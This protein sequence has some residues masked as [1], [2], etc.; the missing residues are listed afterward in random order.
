MTMC[1]LLMMLDEAL[2]SKAIID[3]RPA[4]AGDMA[5]TCADL[6]KAE[7]LLGYRPKVSLAE[8]LHDF[9]AWLV[10]QLAG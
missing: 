6:T 3:L 8:G 1:E 5:V 4:V 2:G 10:N 7:R 9:V